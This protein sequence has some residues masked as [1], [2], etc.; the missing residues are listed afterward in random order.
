MSQQLGARHVGVRLEPRRE[1]AGD[2]GGLC[3]SANAGSELHGSLAFG[4][5]ELAEEEQRRA[6]LGRDPVRV[7]PSGVQVGD[8]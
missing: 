4:D 1:S 3:D 6:R 7:A 8:L 2:P 5:G